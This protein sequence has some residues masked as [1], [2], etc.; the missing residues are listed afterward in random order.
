MRGIS[1]KSEMTIFQYPGLR[2]I[3]DGSLKE[4]NMRTDSDALSRNGVANSG[5]NRKS[6]G[7]KNRNAGSIR[8]SQSNGKL[9]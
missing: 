7:K 1:V 5:D 3:M 8:I 6:S 9:R 2:N 4:L